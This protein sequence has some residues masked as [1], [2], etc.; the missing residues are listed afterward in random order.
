MN[1]CRFGI[2]NVGSDFSGSADED[3]DDD[4]EVKKVLSLGISIVISSSL[5][6]AFGTV[7][8]LEVC[9]DINSVRFGTS[10]VARRA[11]MLLRDD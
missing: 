3:D 8:F 6:C 11:A 9:W 10:K 4:D 2:V 7:S 5:N 1:I